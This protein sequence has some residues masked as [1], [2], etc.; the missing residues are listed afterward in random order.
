VADID[1]DGQLDLICGRTELNIILGDPDT[2]GL[3][4]PI[5][6]GPYN[7]RATTSTQAAQGLAHTMS[8]VDVDGDGLDDV[9]LLVRNISTQLV[10]VQW[11]RHEVVGGEVTFAPME[12]LFE[13]QPA[14]TAT[15][16]QMRQVAVADFTGNGLPDIAFTLNPVSPNTDGGFVLLRNVTEPG[17]TPEFEFDAQLDALS[18]LHRSVWVV[19]LGGPGPDILATRREGTTT[20][21]RNEPQWLTTLLRNDGDGNFTAEALPGISSQTFA[22]AVDM[23]GDGLIDIVSP[24]NWRGVEVRKQLPDGSFAPPLA[25]PVTVPVTTWVGVTDVTTTAN[26]TSSPCAATNAQRSTSTRCWPSPSTPAPGWTP[27]PERPIWLSSISKSA[28]A[29]PGSTAPRRSRSPRRPPSPSRPRSATTA[30]RPAS[31][32]PAS[33]C[34]CPPTPPGT[35]TTRPSAKPPPSPRSPPGPRATVSL[36]T[37]LLP[38]V[39]GE[40]Y[41]IG[42]VDP[43]RSIPDADRDNNE[44]TARIDVT[45]PDLVAGGSSVTV[46]PEPGR[47]ALVRLIGTAAPARVTVQGPDGIVTS[48]RAG[49]VPLGALSDVSHFGAG[50]F[51][52]PDFPGDRYLRVEGTGSVTLSAE[53]L[54]F[55]IATVT[56]TTAGNTGTVTF[57]LSGP[58]ILDAL[59]DP[60]TEVELTHSSGTPVLT[61]SDVSDGGDGRLW[62][63]FDL[64]GVPTG[65]YDLELRSDIQSSTLPD[66]VQVVVPNPELAGESQLSV[67]TFVPP[68]GR[69]MREYDAFV[70]FRNLG[71]TDLVAPFISFETASFVQPAHVT[72]LDY[73]LPVF[74]PVLTPGDPVGVMSP[75][76]S[77]SASLRF[78][79]SE[80][81]GFTA[82]VYSA[83]S[84][85]PVDWAAVLLDDLPGGLTDDQVAEVLD[86]LVDTVGTTSG[87]F[88]R[89]A[90]AVR[91]EIAADGERIDDLE[92]LRKI[93]IDRALAQVGGALVE[94]R[95][96]DADG[97]PVEGMGL[98]LGDG[99]NDRRTLTRYDGRFTFLDDGTAPLASPLT[100]HAVA[101]GPASLLDGLA[102]APGVTLDVGD[103]ELPSGWSTLRGMVT[104]GGSG[105]PAPNVAVVVRDTATNATTAVI[106]HTDGSYGFAGISA[107]DI[108]VT[109]LSDQL[110]PALPQALEVT[111]GE[112]FVLD[113]EVPEGATIIGLVLGPD[114]EPATDAVVHLSGDIRPLPVPVESDG[115]FVLSG[116]PV[117]DLFIEI[118]APGLVGQ[119]LETSNLLAGEAVDVGVVQLALGGTV[120]GTVTD[121][122]GN[123]IEGWASA[124]VRR[125]WP[126][127]SPP[128]TVRSSS[129]GWHPARGWSSPG[130]RAKL[131]S[132]PPSRWLPEKRSTWRFRCCRRAPSRCW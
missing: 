90:Q 109:T 52:V 99:T 48:S 104:M 37:T 82:V 74:M 62:A 72:D 59:L 57:R 75:G 14:A 18:T 67:S 36:V 64:T 1:G 112:E 39:S 69:P 53:A 103:V 96:V 11:A 30:Q 107:G 12:E 60:P 120:T 41:V 29:P 17:E 94:G 79:A 113:L 20:D 70:Y 6:L 87:S 50:P 8:V 40:Q 5:D 102:P 46:N 32:A 116:V 126:A 127:I 80:R 54:P 28:S 114:A 123:P 130:T 78:V 92:R 25:V 85:S 73:S 43:R 56:P 84:T 49:V 115:T 124:C 58:G 4:A 27:A 97:D 122:D 95:L 33:A 98:V 76:A 15:S 106:S 45:M 63:V 13:Y 16:N 22:V 24:S 68:I 111:S 88:V 35:R 65:T 89:A 121:P 10:T 71:L 31:P 44:R 91:A 132:R 47:P 108:E 105:D 129:T 86:I 34:R 61:T 101:Y 118:T 38:T 23:D 26:P 77:G 2:G 110:F 42:R 51:L 128:P 66:A 117:G 119:A 83:D 7:L 125:S 93:L 55:G 100:L 9:L 81:Y 21:G 19:D 3:A 131:A